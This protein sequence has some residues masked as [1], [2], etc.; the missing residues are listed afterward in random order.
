VSELVQPVFA[1]ILGGYRLWTIDRCHI[2][3][4]KMLFNWRLCE[5]EFDEMTYARHWCYYDNG[6]HGLTLLCGNA[7]AWQARGFE[8]EPEG[9]IKAYDGRRAGE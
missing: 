2:D 4:I 3:A 9:W 6:P 8:G 7:L 5:T 1:P